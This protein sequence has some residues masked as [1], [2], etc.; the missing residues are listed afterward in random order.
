MDL[1]EP[2]LAVLGLGTTE[3]I[4]IL[5]LVLIVFG[6]GKLPQVGEALGASIKNFKKASEEPVNDKTAS[7]QTDGALA[8]ASTVS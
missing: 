1:S 6:V 2:L 8:P 4:I 5:V 3:L 7:K